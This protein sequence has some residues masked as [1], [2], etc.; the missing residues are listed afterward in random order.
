M[1]AAVGRPRR[2]RATGLRAAAPRRRVSAGRPAKPSRQRDR[3]SVDP[4]PSCCVSACPTS[5]VR[6]A[7]WRRPSVRPAATSRRSRSSRSAT[8]APPRRRIP[9]RSSGHDAGLDRL[10]LQRPRRG[11]RCVWISRYAAG[12]NVFLDLEAVEELT[13]APGQALDRLVE[14]LPEVFRSTGARGC[15]ASGGSTAPRPRPTGWAGPRSSEPGLVEGPDEDLVVACPLGPRRGAADRPP[16]R[17][18]VPRLRAGAGSSTSPTWPVDRL[19]KGAGRAAQPA[20]SSRKSGISRS[21]FFWYSPYVGTSVSTARCHHSS[22]SGPSGSSRATY[23]VLVGAVLQ[24]DLR[25]GA[26][27]VRPRPG[28]PARRR[29]SATAR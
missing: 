14:L 19:L 8:T 17:A 26:E 29:T 22:R 6:W 5:P 9:R 11:R 16:R 10:G 2:T 27:V 21:V 20:R 15:T 13:A 28:R 7:G 25:V 23:V 1:R 24:V 4:C 18:G 3:V 12:G